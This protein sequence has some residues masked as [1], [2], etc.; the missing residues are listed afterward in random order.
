MVQHPKKKLESRTHNQQ[1]FL[2]I[3]R[4]VSASI[5]I[6]F[7]QM[8]VK[9]LCEALDA[10]CVYIAEFV[11]GPVARVRTVAACVESEKMEAFEFPLAGS[12]D[13]GVASGNTCIYASGV[14]DLFPS[15]RRL[16]DLQ[17]EAFVG[18][19][20]PDSQ[21]RTAGLMV[22]I[23][24]EPLGEEAQFVQSMLATF[25]PRAAAELNRKQADDS[26]RESEQRYRAFIGLNPVAMWRIEFD[27]PI[28]THLPEEQQLDRMYQL[29]YVAECNIAAARLIG[30]DKAEKAIGARLG[31]IGNSETIREAH[32][33]LLQSGHRFSMIE[34]TLADSHLLLNHWGIVEQ[35]L[36]QRVW[37]TA[38]NITELRQ[39]QTGLATS[40]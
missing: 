19:P 30:F 13:P 15:D 26:L 5:G 8:I 28:A 10:H 23:Y 7:F 1:G 29:G 11:G 4:Q 20:L 37:C 25:A 34:T 33:H 3:A 21:G 18:L 6:E 24:R 14:R 22:A 2:A 35:G 31:E 16:S 12:P 9:H 39:Y 40:Q 36:L 27:K 32:R 38:L 17:A